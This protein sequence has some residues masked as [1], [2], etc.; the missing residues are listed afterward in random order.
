[1]VVVVVVISFIVVVVLGFVTDYFEAK[2]LFAACAVE[3]LLL[4]EQEAHCATP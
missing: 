3:A 2:N 4:P 1:M